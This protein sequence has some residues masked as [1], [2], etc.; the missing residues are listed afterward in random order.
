MK[1][2]NFDNLPLLS[3][4]V[5][6]E[7]LKKPIADLKLSSDYYKAVFH[8]AKYPGQET[9]DALLRVLESQ[10]TEQPILIAKRKAVD[11]LAKL[12][13]K[14]AIPLIADCLKSNDKYLVENAVWALKELGCDNPKLHIDII[15]LLDNPDQNRRLIIQS[16]ALMG[17]ESAIPKINLLIKD[18]SIS[19]SVKGAAIAAVSRLCGTHENIS[20][21]KNHLFLPNQNDR[22]CAVHDVIDSQA[23]DLLFFVLKAPVAPIFRIK[24]LEALWPVEK[25]SVNNLEL[26][27]TVQSL[28]I[29]DPNNLDMIYDYDSESNIEL[30]VDGLFNTDF[31]RSYPCLK[32]LINMETQHIWPFLY[33]SLDSASKDYGALYFFLMLFLLKDKWGK[34]QKEKIEMI[35]LSALSQ[36]WPDYIKFKPAAIMNLMSIGPKKYKSFIKNWLNEDKTPFWVCRFACL[37]SLET[38][39]LGKNRDELMELLSSCKSDSHIFVRFKVNQLINSF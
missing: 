23:S 18:T 28:I 19:I 22:H 10:S 12:D 34:D 15:H 13:C 11:S 26:L 33:P 1:V 39:L 24:A 5:A 20:D 4:E 6:L 3:K 31:A 9:E 25:L 37:I 30:L 2:G 21:L 38:Q 8:L 16:L 14:N 36:E 17:V 27:S 7:I 29:D 32:K 35:S